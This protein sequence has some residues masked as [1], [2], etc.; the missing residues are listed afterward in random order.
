VAVGKLS[1]PTIKFPIKASALLMVDWIDAG[2][3]PLAIFSLAAMSWWARSISPFPLTG[4][5]MI[6][7]NCAAL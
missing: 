4:V 6:A 3:A 5:F 2:S 1:L 7:H